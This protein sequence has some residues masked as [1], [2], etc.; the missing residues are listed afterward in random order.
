MS[1][2][3]LTHS[4]PDHSHSY[5]YAIRPKSLYILDL[6]NLYIGKINTTFMIYVFYFFFTILHP[7]VTHVIIQPTYLLL[8]HFVNQEND[9]VEVLRLELEGSRFKLH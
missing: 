2:S 7:R 8:S 4:N 6:Y 9:L 5:C 3:T 1:N